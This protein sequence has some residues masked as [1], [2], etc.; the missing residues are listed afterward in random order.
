MSPHPGGP[1]TTLPRREVTAVV[2]YSVP[3]VGV[4]VARTNWHASASRPSRL[5]TCGKLLEHL[6]KIGADQIAALVQVSGVPFVA[7][8]PKVG[9]PLAHIPAVAVLREELGD[10]VT[11]LAR[12]S[13]A[14]NLQHVQ[15]AGDI[16]EGEMGAETCYLLHRPAARLLADELLS[17]AIE[18]AR[19]LPAGNRENSDRR[20]RAAPHRHGPAKGACRLRRAERPRVRL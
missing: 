18:G 10:D 1:A 14:L 5:C 13:R 3:R 16:A 11:A 17:G 7:V 4:V 20:P 12:A 15:L 9:H 19:R 2:T 8:A 6:R